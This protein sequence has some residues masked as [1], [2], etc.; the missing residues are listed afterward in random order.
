MGSRYGSLSLYALLVAAVAGIWLVHDLV[1]ASQFPPWWGA[2]LCIGACL[3]VWRFGLTAPRVVLTSMER[4][5]QIGAL[6]IFDPAVAA[7]ICALASFLWPF[8]NRGYSY[9]SLKV[10]AIRGLHNGGMT[11][12]MLLTAGYAYLAAGGMHPLSSVRLQDIWPLAAMALAT[13]AVNVALMALYYFF[14]GRDVRRLIKPIYSLIDLIFVPAGVLAALLYNGASLTT[15]WLFAALMVLFVLSFNGIGSSLDV[16]E[17]DSGPFARLW[18]TRRALHGARRIDDLGERILIE[19]RNLFRFDEFYF[20]LVDRE[21]RTLDLRVHERNGARQPMR[22]KPPDAGLFGWAV[23]NARSLLIENW[24]QAPEALAPASR[25]DGQG[26]RLAPRRA[27]DR[28]TGT[29]IGLL[30]VQHSRTGAYSEAD[31]HLI[32]HLAEQ[33]SAAVADARVFEDLENYRQ[34]LE[35]RVA[36]RTTELQQANR[37]KEHLIAAL[38]ERSRTLERESQEDPLTG[39]ANRRQFNQ[40]LAAEIATAGTTD[41]PLTLAVADLD[42]FKI[43]NDRLGHAI[44]D[45]VLRHTAEIMRRQCRAVDLVARIGGEEFALVLSGMTRDVATGYCDLL[46]RAF[47]VAR[48][49]NDSPAVASDAQHWHF[50]VGRFSRPRR[51]PAGRGR[52]ALLRQECGAQPRGVTVFDPAR[53]RHMQ[54]AQRDRLRQKVIHAAGKAALPV[55]VEG[56]RRHRNHGHIVVQHA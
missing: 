54:V 34:H 15:F 11:A 28:R 10:A 3:F 47:E 38:N 20:A 27:A 55:V 14:D 19:T 39:I 56:V 29:V 53:Q 23:E 35:E 46:R 21:D 45:E 26:N 43:V 44:G 49:A 37:D 4:L 6:L 13:Q 7:G 41:R 40:R 33:V 22:R 42:H 31:L 8:V 18:H 2:A 5:P 51:L 1:G 30:S 32:E 9:G 48:L 24:S 52:S 17:R 50:A 36:E 16:A 12:L 25:T